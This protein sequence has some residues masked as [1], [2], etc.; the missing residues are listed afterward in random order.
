M[1]VVGHVLRPADDL[2]FVGDVRDFDRLAR[3]N[4]NEIGNNKLIRV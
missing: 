3:H 2:A 4:L 1:L